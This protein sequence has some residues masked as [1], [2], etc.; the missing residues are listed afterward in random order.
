MSGRPLLSRSMMR[1]VI[2]NS[3]VS[4]LV[5]CLVPYT[6]KLRRLRGNV[7]IR[8]SL[9]VAIAARRIAVLT[10]TVIAKLSVA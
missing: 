6:A 2:R 7:T 9:T 10:M 8:T 5:A 1:T 3:N 4:Y